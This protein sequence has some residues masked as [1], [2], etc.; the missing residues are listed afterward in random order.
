MSEL[1]TGSVRDMFGEE[2]PSVADASLPI[3]GDSVVDTYFDGAPHAQI[4][5]QEYI[6]GLKPTQYNRINEIRVQILQL[7]SRITDI[8]PLKDRLSD[9][10]VSGIA[11][12][13]KDDE[14][15]ALLSV[16]EL[17]KDIATEDKLVKKRAMDLYNGLLEEKQELL[18]QIDALEAIRSE[19]YLD[20]RADELRSAS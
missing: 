17:F 19:L 5:T 20:I 13:G 9:I 14:L 12:F 1:L 3:P 8:E 10:S 2:Y 15:D 6:D 16:E 4:D 11:L 7:K 18:L